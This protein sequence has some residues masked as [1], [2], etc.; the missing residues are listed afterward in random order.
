M[1]SSTCHM[2]PSGSPFAG[3][4]YVCSLIML[5]KGL[6]STSVVNIFKNTTTRFS[7][8]NMFRCFKHHQPCFICKSLCNEP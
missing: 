3:N 6:D 8:R 5:R 7:F 1:T 2:T 4:Y